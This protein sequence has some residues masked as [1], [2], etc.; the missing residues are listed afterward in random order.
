MI[1][2]RIKLAGFLCYK[3]EQEINFD[4]SSLWMLA[5]M[6][7]SGKSSIFDAVTYALFNCH[8]GGSKG[9][10]DLINKECKSLSVEFEFEIQKQC[11]YIRRTY[12]KN[13]QGSG[14]GTQQIYGADH[15][16][17]FFPVP[18]TQLQREFDRWIEQ[19][20]GLNYE[21]FTSS[22][23]LR[24][25]N[26][27]K[28]LEAR[29]T[30][31]AKV[32]SG[33]VD[34]ERYIQ[35]H[36]K[37][38][39]LRRKAK[40]SQETTANQLNGIPEVTEIEWAA[41]ENTIAELEDQYKQ[42]ELVV[43]QLNSTWIS[44]TAWQAEQNRLQTLQ[45]RWNDSQAMFKNAADIEKRYTRFIEL[46][47]VIPHSMTIQQHQAKLD[48]SHRTTAT[49]NEKH[50]KNQE[51]LTKQ[52]SEHQLASQQRQKIQVEL[53][54][55]EQQLVDQNAEILRLAPLIAKLKDYEE[56]KVKLAE[57][58]KLLKSA[59]IVS[60][61]LL[62]QWQ[63]KLEELQQQA[64]QLPRLE[65][66]AKQRSQLIAINAKNKALH[67]HLQQ[68]MIEGKTLRVEFDACQLKL[69][70]ATKQRTA[71]DEAVTEAKTRLSDWERSINELSTL[72]G[73]KTC[74]ACGMPLTPEHVALEQAKRTKEL[75]TAQQTL[76]EALKK[77]SVA[78]ATE[79]ALKTQQTTL[80][81]QLTKLR[82]EVSTARAEAKAVDQQSISLNEQCTAEYTALA[83]H[84]QRQIA[85]APLNDWSTTV[86][87]TP[88]DISTIRQ[89]IQ[90]SDPLKK[91]IKAAQDAMAKTV[92]LQ[93]E[94]DALKRQLHAI[95]N[96]LPEG[97]PAKLREQE[98]HHQ[99]RKSSL[100]DRIKAEK[101]VILNLEK[102]IERL[103]KEIAT[104]QQKLAETSSLLKSQET[105]REGY[106]EAI[107]RALELIPE[108]F[109]LAAKQPSF[110]GFEKWKTEFDELQRDK[111]EEKHKEL[112][113]VRADIENLKRDI[114][115][116]TEKIEAIPFE[117]RR[118]PAVVKQELAN[119]KNATKAKG[120][121]LQLARDERAV[122]ERR[123]MQRSELLNTLKQQEYELK[124]NK[125]LAE[126]LG[127][128]RL[129]LHVM[130]EAEKQIVSRAN[131]IL[132]RLSNGNLFL[133]LAI[134]KDGGEADSALDL[135]AI[136]RETGSGPINVTFMSGSQRFRI[137]VSLALA[138][139]QYA[140]KQHRPI[141]SVI[142]D[143]G[144]GCLDRESRT[145]MIQELQN[146]SQQLDRILL[147]SHQEEFADA[148]PNGYKF[149]LVDN[150]TRVTRYQ[151]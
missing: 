55:H 62:E 124:V 137:A 5:G 84:D 83:P 74:R 134:G 56:L 43:E 89:R 32:L 85:A 145:V 88:T 143:E 13:N 24:Q 12:K 135:E 38:D 47:A 33:I 57:H 72:D 113:S 69:T 4:G 40:S 111:I 45:R 115:E 142:I 73:K 17:K 92:K 87:P 102:D 138:I 100:S 103:A 81:D 97:D 9:A 79:D 51:T 131:R 37:A 36:S 105:A 139:G 67:T 110:L 16:G 41:A 1:P 148:F 64:I 63:Q 82:D 77:Q 120:N 109:K 118:D 14:S 91:Q 21:T 112:V 132:E 119:A 6:N 144:F 147:V 48:D 60:P 75:K 70:E 90:E 39:D 28:L 86:W 133:K 129:Q 54:N 42:A 20:I 3:D 125:M 2:K 141:E 106:H 7:G 25:G 31:R 35:L 95:Q 27:E 11:Y 52:Q 149:H 114:A 76:E 150:A 61:K 146:L 26:A 78:R 15:T 151:N 126:L 130:R 108:T 29:P 65:Q 104:T 140:S 94:M 96:D 18:D 49:L 30:E 8:R 117:C 71:S 66:F 107:Q 59:N 23:L 93:T 19:H 122:L 123:R 116:V 10:I 99:A 128:D 44:A 50:N 53:A 136:N 34:M 121:D 98:V 127:K 22:V 80:N 101:N 58:E 46:K 68:V